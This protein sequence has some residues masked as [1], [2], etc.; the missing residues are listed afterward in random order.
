MPLFG[1]SY[2]HL[3]LGANGPGGMLHI[4]RKLNIDLDIGVVLKELLPDGKVG[5][6]KLYNMA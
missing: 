2:V 4:N 1:G 6:L 5:K 3:T